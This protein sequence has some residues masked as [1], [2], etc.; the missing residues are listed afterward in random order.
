MD[1]QISSALRH[2]KVREN[3]LSLSLERLSSGLRV[4]RASDDAVSISISSRLRYQLSAIS[5]SI[6][7]LNNGISI[8]RTI[9]GALSKIGSLLAR[10][11]NLSLKLNEDTNTELDRETYREEIKQSLLEIEDIVKTTRYNNKPLLAAPPKVLY[12]EGKEYIEDFYISSS[13]PAGTYIMSILSAGKMSEVALPLRTIQDISPSTSLYSA[14]GE[15]VSDGYI[16]TI[17]ITSDGKIVEVPLTISPVNGDTVSSAVDKINNALRENDLNIVAYYDS[18]GKQIVLSSTEAGTRYAIDISEVN[19]IEGARY[20]SSISE[21]TS[22]EGPEGLFTYRKLTYIE[23]YRKGPGVTGGTLLRDYFNC[24][25]P[26]TFEFTGFGGRSV[27]FSISSTYTL[28]YASLLIKNRLRNELGIDVGVTFNS[29]IDR[30]VF[31]YSNPAERLEVSI[32]GG[33]HSEGYEI[34]EAR[35][36]TQLGNIL[37]LQGSLSLTFLDET[38]PVA[39]L[40]LNESS[41]IGDIINAIN[42][43]NIGILASYSDGKINID[44]SNRVNKIFEVVQ[45]GSAVFSIG[46]ETVN[47]GYPVLSPPEDIIF[48]FNDKVYTSNCREF[49]LEGISFTLKKEALSLLPLIRFQITPEPFIISL[50]RERITFALPD[51][52]LSSLGLD[53]LNLSDTDL[54]LSKIEVAVDKVSGERSRIGGL[55]NIF[56]DILLTQDIYKQNLEETDAR[57]LLTDIIQEVSNLGREKALLLLGTSLIGEMSN[58]LREIKLAGYNIGR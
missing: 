14:L 22:L 5:T 4:N 20:F 16:K 37:D 32:T 42:N 21:V 1:I 10:A 41:T 8:L 29:T 35:E 34:I 45:E 9:D 38:G 19:S 31:T 3:L 28:D 51:V 27:S 17:Y 7:N 53:N 26:V 6:D 54:L 2:L 57:L 47:T 50:G 12:I 56:R 40:I 23:G 43:L 25:G 44:Q 55:E 13:L 48:S 33:V 11:R 46:K 24:T 18:E 39:T 52:S 15:S 36:D 58:I 49:R 30:F